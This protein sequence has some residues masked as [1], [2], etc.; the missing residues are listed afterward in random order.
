MTPHNTLMSKLVEVRTL[1]DDYVKVFHPIDGEKARKE[2]DECLITVH[3]FLF[4]DEN[5]KLPEMRK[6]NRVRSGRR[7]DV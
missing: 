6:V 5:Q 3:Q 1:L 2:L 7:K 4:Y